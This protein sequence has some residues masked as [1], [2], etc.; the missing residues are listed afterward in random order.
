VA[1]VS[2]P[3]ACYSAQHRL[4][5]SLH[6]LTLCCY[7]QRWLQ[8]NKYMRRPVAIHSVNSFALQAVAV[9]MFPAHADALVVHGR[10]AHSPERAQARECAHSHAHRHLKRGFRATLTPLHSLHAALTVFLRSGV[11]VRVCLWRVRIL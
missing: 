6:A 2:R 5:R 1:L 3:H 9:P 4:P 10:T 11:C 8:R 7:Q